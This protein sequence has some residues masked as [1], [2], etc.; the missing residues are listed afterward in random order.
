MTSVLQPLD[1]CINLQMDGIT[2]L[3]QEMKWLEIHHQY[4][5]IKCVWLDT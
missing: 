1:V 3:L 4:G 2:W 5:W